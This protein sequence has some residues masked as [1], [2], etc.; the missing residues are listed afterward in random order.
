[1]M[2]TQEVE[3]LYMLIKDICGRLDIRVN[4]EH[5]WSSSDICF[6][7]AT[8]PQIDGLGP[9]GEAP[10]DD[11]EYVLRHSLL[12]RATLLAMLL[13]ALRQKKT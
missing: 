10:H 11:E 2:R 7:E 9:V 3:H 12:D 1:M 6:A 5:R 13:D 4:E 8:K